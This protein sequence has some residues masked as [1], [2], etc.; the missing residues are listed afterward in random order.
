MNLT[1]MKNTVLAVLAAAGSA[2]AQALGG[3]DVAL[4]VLICFMALDYVTGWLVAAIWHKSAKSK[5]GALDSK[6]SYKGLVKKGVM[7]SL[8]WMAALLDQATHSDFVRDAVCLFFIANEGLSVLENTAVMGVPYPAFVKKMLDALHQTG[9]LLST[10]EG[11]LKMAQLLR[12][13]VA[14]GCFHWQFNIVD[15]SVLL[16]AQKDPD[17]YRSLVVRVAGYS[18]IFVE[19]SVKAQ[20]SIIERYAADL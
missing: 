3:W 4:K 15:N 6:A 16:A 1:Q 8:V 20:N 5:T 11:R 12:A 18:A 10:E 17:S 14:Q 7:L 19:L 9:S 13:F 2:V